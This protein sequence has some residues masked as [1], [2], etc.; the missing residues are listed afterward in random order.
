MRTSEGLALP[1][2]RTDVRGRI[3]GCVAD[4][5]VK[6]VF[7]NPTSLAI[8]AVYLFPLPHGAA[9]HAMQFTIADRVVKAVVKEKAKAREIYERARAEGR[10]ATLLEEASPTLFSLS[11]ANIPPDAT[12]EVDLG[13]QQLLDFDDGEWRFAFPMVAPERYVERAPEE[14]IGPHAKVAP[15]RI[16]SG[17]RAPDVTLELD[18][19][20]ADASLVRST[21]H[22]VS[23]HTYGHRTRVTLSPKDSIP[24]RDFVLTFRAGDRAVRPSVSF[25]RAP[26]AKDGTFLLTVTPPADP[27]ERPSKADPDLEPLR[28]GNCGGLVASATSIVSIPG[29]GPAFPCGYCGAILTPSAKGRVVKA[30][31][32]RDVAILVDRSRSMRGALPQARRAVQ[33]LLSNLVP[34]DAVQVIAFDHD[35]DAFDGEGKRYVALAP[36]VAKKVETFMAGL[37]PRGGSELLEAFE[38]AAKLPVNRDR[39]QIVVLISDAAFG[40]EGRLLRKAKEILGADRRLFV[41]GLGPS[42]DRRLVERLARTCGGAFDLLTMNEDVE[43]VMARFSRRVRDAGPV[44]TGLSLQ[45]EG[46]G[47]EKV[48]P[49]SIADLY[50]GEP[51]M[52]LGRYRGEGPTK[53]VLTGATANGA[54]FRQEIDVD[55]PVESEDAPGLSRLWARRRIDDLLEDVEPAKKEAIEREVT[56]LAIAHSISSPYTSLVAEDSEVSNR[57][58][59]PV[60]HDVA[61]PVPDGGGGPVPAG[62]MPPPA[63][64]APMGMASRTMAGMA[65]SRPAAGPKMMGRALESADLDL[66]GAAD[67]DEL[68]MSDVS[69]GA[70]A[71]ARYDSMGD[72]VEPVYE[73]ARRSAPRAAPAKGGGGL[74]SRAVDAMKAA[75]TSDDPSE[76][77]PA[78]TEPE[79]PAAPSSDRRG[80]PQHRIETS[81]P[82]E[83]DEL[84][85][86][87]LK[88]VG[89]LDLVFLV[90]ATGSMGAY[91]EQVKLRLLELVEA[92]KKSPL[93]RSLRL[94]LVEY[95]D[96]PPQ[97]T[98]FVTRVTELTE[99][100]A[101]V[102]AAARRMQANGGGDGPE[103]VED[104]LFRVVRL[105]W[106][107]SAARVVVWFGDA[108]PHGVV[109][110]GD[111]FPNGC[112]DGIHWYT[113]A[114]SCREMGIAVYAVGCRPGIQSFP[115]AEDMFKTVASTARGSY[116]PLTDARLLISAIAGAAMAELDKQRIDEKVAELCAE[117]D[118]VL[119]STDDPER[120]RWIAERMR[121]GG[122]RAYG[123]DEA[124][125]LAFRD[126][127]TTDV[128]GSLDRLRA[129]HRVSF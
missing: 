90:D 92:L 106:R 15:P 51:V 70:V 99:D 12:I 94:G 9:V 76:P 89:A 22:L 96:H 23:S 115:G 78:A 4:V 41:L 35:R 52:V 72:D 123:I 33:A 37:E 74:L 79:P 28:C 1:L 49:A 68:C 93:L 62:A 3:A 111:G 124:A 54:P 21:T 121:S 127:A 101:S 98:T 61:A 40:N 129:A 53:L 5:E 45:W 46:A 32:P 109:P 14:A 67:E 120:V 10:A 11:V 6:Q 122:V 105:D 104:G 63:P 55:L 119:R 108:P 66:A 128:E 77:A 27:D 29:L 118:G 126:L 88:N 87:S 110:Y 69:T 25:E 36:E 64:M 17:D 20:V 84:R 80:P 91:I 19:G 95:R 24:N 48:H 7:T 8:E 56:E 86:L 43:P 82:Y 112:P 16:P 102:E 58:G 26:G 59:P 100:I 81:S 50:G 44:L 30:T 38:R 65:P 34:G 103:A 75:F 107:P 85:W 113:Q 71:P 116:L 2:S 97:D 73:R 114:E 47:I 39:A 60:R 83:A 31:R 42:V 13:Y 18:I 57:A 117:H 125:N